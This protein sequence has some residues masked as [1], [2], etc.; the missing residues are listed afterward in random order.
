MEWRVL[1]RLQLPG[2]ISAPGRFAATKLLPLPSIIHLKYILAQYICL[3]ETE[4]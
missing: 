1:L 2:T 4:F 3:I